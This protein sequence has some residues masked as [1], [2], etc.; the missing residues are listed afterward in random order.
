MNSLELYVLDIIEGRRRSPFIRGL[1]SL[2]SFLY[3]AGVSVRNAFYDLRWSKQV[4]ISVP[5]VS[6]G[7]IVAG[8]VGKTPLVH[9]LAKEL[10]P[11]RRVAILSRGYLAPLEKSN[12]LAHSA[13]MSGD[14]PYWLSAALPQAQ[15]WVGRDRAASARLACQHKAELIL[16][17]D[18]MQHRRLARDVELVV[19]DAEDLFGRGYFLPRGLLRDSPKRLARADLIV[20]N[21]IRNA[22]HLEELRGSIASYSAA[23]L[24]GIRMQMEGNVPNQKVGV[25]CG[26]AKPRRFL[27]MVAERG[28]Q[29]VSQLITPDHVAPSAGALEAF[30]LE[31][32]AKGAD[33]LLCTEKDAVKLPAGLQSCLPIRAVKAEL[34]IVAGQEHWN[35][36]IESLKRK[37]S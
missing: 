12:Q 3:S 16:L 2:C 9:L 33:M 7:N 36:L 22:A 1:L 8:G 34:E 15:V 30:A 37:G 26:I 13:A 27:S 18:G 21:H 4:R 29:V 10:L 11:F 24:V 32:Q 25:F 35:K 28:A 17:D 19:L 14:E 20:V 5:V 23:P 6:I 31:C